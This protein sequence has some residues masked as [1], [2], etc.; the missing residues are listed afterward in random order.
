MAV[1]RLWIDSDSAPG[2]DMVP[3]SQE[4]SGA[5]SRQ[6][7]TAY[8]L[9]RSQARWADTDSAFYLALWCSLFKDQHHVC[10]FL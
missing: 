8:V 3:R 6:L 10:C 4:L 9:L 1:N 5:G 7:L 2:I